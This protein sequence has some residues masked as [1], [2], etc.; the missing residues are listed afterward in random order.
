MRNMEAIPYTTQL[1]IS[2]AL[3]GEAGG[4]GGENIFWKY[5]IS[6][7]IDQIHDNRPS[8][9]CTRFRIDGI[10]AMSRSIS[11]G[12]QKGKICQCKKSRSTLFIVSKR[13]DDL[14]V[15]QNVRFE[16]RQN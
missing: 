16:F 3:H 15:M 13:N 5:T 8:R 11:G 2:V 10:K 12:K 14:I 7:T 6:L 4:G 1:G 9:L